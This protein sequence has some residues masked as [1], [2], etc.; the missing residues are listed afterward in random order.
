MKTHLLIGVSIISTGISKVCSRKMFQDVVSLT[1]PLSSFA[2][3]MT[4]AVVI[5]CSGA[6]TNPTLFLQRHTLKCMKFTF[7]TIVFIS[8]LKSK[9]KNTS[10]INHCQYTPSRGDSRV[11]KLIL[12][13]S[14]KTQITFGFH[15]QKWVKTAVRPNSTHS[16][17]P[18]GISTY[19]HHIHFHCIARTPLFQWRD[20]CCS[21]TNNTNMSCALST[22]I[23]WNGSTVLRRIK[24]Y[25]HTLHSRKSINL[26]FHCVL[27]TQLHRTCSNI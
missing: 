5:T 26:I 13:W 7:K 10:F 6:I 17:S 11:Q 24:F 21:P 18:S 19:L 2:V 27:K 23:C 15:T 22:E 25:V 1:V 20:T 4:A 16:V 8:V 14:R 9:K 3:T 12:T